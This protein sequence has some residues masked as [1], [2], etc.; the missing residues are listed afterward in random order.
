MLSSA[1][2]FL[3]S[4]LGGA[5]VTLP[6]D[7]KVK[8]TEIELGELC[9]VAGLDGELVARVRALELGYAPAP[10]FSRLLTAERIRAE[11]A[12]ALPGVEIRVTGESRRP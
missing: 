7:A 11:L 3:G 10:G 9:L 4:A 2:L 6:V 5:T 1:L 8:G 12:R